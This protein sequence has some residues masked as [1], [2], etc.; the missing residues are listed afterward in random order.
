MEGR[1]ERFEIRVFEIG[2]DSD[3]SRFE[4]RDRLEWFEIRAFEMRGRLEGFE[5]GA[6]EI[7]FQLE[8]TWSVRSSSIRDAVST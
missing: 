4:L 6:F 3:G 5:I 2:V 1:L 7:G 8:K